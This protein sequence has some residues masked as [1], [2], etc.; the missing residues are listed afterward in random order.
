MNL[1]PHHALCIQKFTGHGYDENFTAHMTAVV[2]E[3][4][5][6][7]QAQIT[8]TK[9]CDK[10]CG[11]CPNNVS[12]V[13]TSLDKVNYMDSAVLEICGID[14]GQNIPWT[15]LAKSARK[16]IFDTD[17]FYRVCASC[18]WFGLCTNTEVE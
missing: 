12:G 13:C 10:L 16:R 8:V 11:M 3:L 5:K 6:N 1:R 14:Y 7:P 4:A 18:Q 15:D 2:S 9:G 17:E